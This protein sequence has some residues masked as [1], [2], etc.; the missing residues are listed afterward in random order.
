MGDQ[1]GEGRLDPR[2]QSATPR[3]IRL[4]PSSGRA[5]RVT[6]TL[7]N[8]IRTNRGRCLHRRQP[9]ASC[10]RTAPLAVSRARP[11]IASHGMLI[12]VG[13]CISVSA[14]NESHRPRK[15]SPGSL[16]GYRMAALHNQPIDFHQQFGLQKAHIVHHRLIRVE[17]LPRSDIRVA[18]KLSQCTMLVHQLVK[19]I[20]ITA[21]TLLDHPITR[22][23]HI[24]IPGRPTLRWTPGRTCSSSS[25]NSQRRN[26]SSA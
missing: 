1:L 10:F 6:H 14:A 11:R 12:S 3:E 22:I 9:G 4:H 2:H 5:R 7:W 13:S 20:E 18:E 21:Q 15:G 23:R 17:G 8:R 26:R 24:S 16:P 19:P 25:A